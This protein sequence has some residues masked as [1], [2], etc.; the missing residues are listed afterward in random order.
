MHKHIQLQLELDILLDFQISKTLSNPKLVNL[1]FEENLLGVSTDTQI[2][3]L[4]WYQDISNNITHHLQHF[5][6]CVCCSWHGSA[7][8]SDTKF[9]IHGGYNGNNALSDTFV[10]DIGERQLTGTHSHTV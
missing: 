5:F 7:V 9:L 1:G 8:L 2:L 6:V 3:Y 4:R 10:F